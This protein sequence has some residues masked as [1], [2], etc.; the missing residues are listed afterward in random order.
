MRDW[1]ASILTTS[2]HT[3][4]NLP[5]SI[6]STVS[7]AR[8]TFPCSNF[9]FGSKNE[10]CFIAS[11]SGEKEKHFF[12]VFWRFSVHY[13]IL[14]SVRISFSSEI[15]V[16]SYQSQQTTAFH[17]FTIFGGGWVCLFSHSN[18]FL[19]YPVTDHSSFWR[20]CIQFIQSTLPFHTPSKCPG[21]PRVRMQPHHPK[22][23]TI[24]R[25]RNHKKVEK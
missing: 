6:P 8:S 4:C 23:N 25:K 3:C 12:S 19:M 14:L 5:S 13:G 10:L 20:N 9:L 15:W 17:C 22:S 1:E 11:Y 21:E 16:T 7:N 24:K 2:H 18:S